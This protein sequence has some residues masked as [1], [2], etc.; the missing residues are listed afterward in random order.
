[1]KAINRSSLRLIHG[2]GVLFA[3][4][5]FAPSLGA[6]FVNGGF[7]SGALTG[8]T[9]GGGTFTSPSALLNPADYQAGGPRYNAGYINNTVVTGFQDPRTDNVLNSVYS[10]TYSVRVNDAVND[11]SVST[12]RQSVTGYSD[13][14]VFFAWAAVLE[15]AHGPTEAANFTLSLRDDTLGTDLYN[16]NYN[17][18]T[19]GPLFTFSSSGWYYTAWQVQDLV[20]TPGH[21]L[22]LTLLAADCDQG[23]HAGYVYLDGFGAIAPPPGP[24]AVPEPSTYGAMG[25]LLLIGLVIA[26]RCRT[27]LDV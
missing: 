9:G 23:G 19:N 12:I 27:V 15:A 20:V 18:S 8:W 5:A 22:T 21:D 1:M 16:V 17:S 6:Q 3:A 7:E 25:V 26:R 24:A 4:I 2:L 14:H 10:G 13:S 11:W